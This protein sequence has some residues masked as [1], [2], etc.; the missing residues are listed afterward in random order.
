MQ[1]K[2]IEKVAKTNEVK[3]SSFKSSEA[4]IDGP[5]FFS[6]S[7]KWVGRLQVRTK[8]TNRI[9]LIF[10]SKMKISIIFKVTWVLLN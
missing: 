5:I 1:K 3:W 9:V 7:N 6:K 10:Y 8:L 4:K 2:I